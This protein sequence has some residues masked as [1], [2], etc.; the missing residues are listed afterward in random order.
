MTSLSATSDDAVDG[1]TLTLL[2]LLPVLVALV[3]T[4]AAAVLMKPEVTLSVLVAL[5]V[6]SS[7]T[8]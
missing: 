8:T 4:V 5:V 3:M 1:L 7:A 2:T 6:L